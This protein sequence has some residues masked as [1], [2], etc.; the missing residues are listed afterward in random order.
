[1][2]VKRLIE[3]SA[4][5]NIGKSLPTCSIVAIS[6]FQSFDFFHEYTDETSNSVVKT[7]NESRQK[8]GSIA[9]KALLASERI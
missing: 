4:G 5:P 1:M 9:V 2:E 6:T 8:D 3:G 7:K